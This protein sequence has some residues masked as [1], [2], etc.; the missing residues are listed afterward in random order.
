VWLSYTET[1]RVDGLSHPFLIASGH[2]PLT[3]APTFEVGDKSI[4]DW[5]LVSF[6][7]ACL[8]QYVRPGPS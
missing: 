8:A 7:A 3:D 4:D 5:T 6:S 2:I 1:W